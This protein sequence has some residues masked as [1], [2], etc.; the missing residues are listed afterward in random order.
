MSLVLRD[1]QSIAQY[2]LQHNIIS[3]KTLQKYYVLC[4]IPS[5]F[6][7]LIPQLWRR[8]GTLFYTWVFVWLSVLLSVRNNNTVAFCKAIIIV[9]EYNFYTLFDKA[10]FMAGS[11]VNFLLNMDFVHFNPKFFEQ[12][13]LK[14]FL[15]AIRWY[16]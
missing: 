3:D 15:V 11:N 13:F 4:R 1:C 16:I 9:G 7:T 6:F 2:A 14:D 5:F 8:R 12:I 10:C